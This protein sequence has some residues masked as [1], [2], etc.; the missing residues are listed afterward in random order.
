MTGRLWGLLVVEGAELKGL[1]IVLYPQCPRAFGTSGRKALQKLLQQ[2]RL[3]PIKKMV[4]TYRHFLTE[5]Y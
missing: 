4:L 1:E 2:N 5:C 3:F